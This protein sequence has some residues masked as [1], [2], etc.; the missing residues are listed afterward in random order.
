ML[1]NLDKDPNEQT[2]L[3]AKHPEKVETLA[4]KLDRSLKEMKA[5]MPTANPD[6]ETSAKALNLKTTKALAEKEWRLFESRLKQ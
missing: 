2:D 5:E 3:T 6:F 4:A 1:Y